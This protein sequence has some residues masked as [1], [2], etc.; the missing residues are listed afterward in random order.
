MTYRLVPGASAPANILAIQIKAERGIWTQSF[1]P[2]AHLRALQTWRTPQL[3]GS[4]VLKAAGPREKKIA[5]GYVRPNR[6]GTYCP[7]RT[8]EGGSLQ[9]SMSC[10]WS[11]RFPHLLAKM[12]GFSTRLHTAANIAVLKVGA[13]TMALGEDS[14]WARDR[15]VTFFCKSILFFL[16]KVFEELLCTHQC[17]TWNCMSNFEGK[18][19]ILLL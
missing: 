12:M 5:M 19:E 10:L 7:P 17:E 8:P 1:R 16:W 18:K 14:T 13:A 3:V 4:V 11:T 15:C 2:Q 6:A 9:E